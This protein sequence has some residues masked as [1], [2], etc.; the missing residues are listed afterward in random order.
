LLV[1][2]VALMLACERRRRMAVAGL[3]AHYTMQELAD[4]LDTIERYECEGHCPRVLAV[5]KRIFRD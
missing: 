1:V 2:F 3:Y 5:T 4:E